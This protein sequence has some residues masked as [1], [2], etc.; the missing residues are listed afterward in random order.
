MESAPVSKQVGDNVFAGTNIRLGDIKVKVEKVGDDTSLARIVHM[1]EDAHSRRAPIQNYANRM[2][3]S[4]VPVSFIAAAVVYLATRDLQ[5]V[6]NMLFID[7]S[8]GLKLVLLLPCQ[9][10]FH[11]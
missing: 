9:L 4:L 5:R 7:F 8:C 11:V 3:A 10:Q 2:A 1:V 6:L